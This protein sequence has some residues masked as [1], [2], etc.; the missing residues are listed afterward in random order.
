MLDIKKQVIDRVRAREA[1][2]AE[3]GEVVEPLALEGEVA[4]EEEEPK[5][6]ENFPVS[7]RGVG[8]YANYG[9]GNSVQIE[10]VGS[11]A[12]TQAEK[13]KSKASKKT[14]VIDT[15]IVQEEGDELLLDDGFVEGEII[16]SEIEGVEPR[17]LEGFDSLVISDNR[18]LAL[19]PA[20]DEIIEADVVTLEEL[21]V[22]PEAKEEYGLSEAS[23]FTEIEF[24][25]F[26]FEDEGEST[27]IMEAE[28]LDNDLAEEGSQFVANSFESQGALAPFYPS[29]DLPFAGFS[30]PKDLDIEDDFA[31]GDIRF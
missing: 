3:E 13:Q 26:E 12:V 30:D 20:P 16:V 1:E 6:Q 27:N 14:E 21:A 7:L 29:E 24:E 5:P 8:S 28:I 25:D 18:R 2:G 22:E 31:Y 19:N 11:Y 17:E 10:G 15:E 23:A 4:E 9:Q